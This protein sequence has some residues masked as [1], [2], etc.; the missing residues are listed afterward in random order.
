M[1]ETGQQPPLVAAGIDSVVVERFSARVAPNQ[2]RKRPAF[3]DSLLRERID[4]LGSGKH[5]GVSTVHK[6]HS[7]SVAIGDLNQVHSSFGRNRQLFTTLYNYQVIRFVRWALLLGILVSIPKVFAADA[8]TLKVNCAKRLGPFAPV[9]AFFGYDEPNYT[10]TEHGKQ[11]IEEL[12]SASYVPVFIRTHNLLTTGDG[13][14]ALKWGSTN[15][16]TEDSQGKAVYDWRIVDQIFDTYLARHAKP[17]V[18]LGFMPE[19]L[20]THPEPYRHTWPKGG[21]DTGWAYPP[22]DYEKWAALVRELV[23]HCVSRYGKAE[24]ASWYW[25]VWNEPNISYWHGTPEEYDK[26]YDYSAHAVKTVL[27]EARVGGPASTGPASAKANAFLTRFLEHCRSGKNAAT[28]KTGAPLDF[29]TFHAKGKPELESG[30]VR[31]GLAQNLRDVQNGFATIRTFPEFRNVP[32][33]LSESDPEG[34]AACGAATYPQNAY[35]NGTLYPAYTAASLKSILDIAGA[36]HGNLAGML[37]WAFEFE[38]QPYF[39]GL[40]TLATN[41][42]DKPVLNLF[43]M[44]GMMTGERVAVESTGAIDAQTIIAKGV[45]EKADV[46]GMAAIH[47]HSLTV[48]LW[49]YQDEAAGGSDSTVKVLLQGAPKDAARLLMEQYRI[50]NTHSNAYTAW[51]RLGSPQHPTEQQYEELR[52]SG[53]LQ[54]MGSPHWMETKQGAA[55]VEV[56]PPPESL[57]LL[58]LS[59]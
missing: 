42:L 56:T 15:A 16:Y 1:I 17:F 8:V 27:A 22:K 31:M 55:T 20:S 36:A 59:W 11:L 41:G 33:I 47:S 51:Q 23:R 49:S 13:K 30:R 25:E 43:R 9:W 50:D 53:Q 54:L 26:L 7:A 29:I 52:Q 3:A 32:V 10:Y 38:D 2:R 4:G 45:R 40:R 6:R 35:R 28:G 58:R 5:F 34:C 37:T 21:I 44:L 39:A 12:G 46:D 19:A 14:P 18:E 48:L 24:A 57:A